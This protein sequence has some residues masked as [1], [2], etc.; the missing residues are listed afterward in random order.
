MIR[1]KLLI[2][3]LI[4][5]EFSFAQNSKDSIQFA[6]YFTGCFKSDTISLSINGTSVFNNKILNTNNSDGIADYWFQTALDSLNKNVLVKVNT[7]AENILEILVNSKLERFGVDIKDGRYLVF[8]KCHGKG[9]YNGWRFL[10]LSQLKN[11]PI[12][13]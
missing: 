4:L 10:S 9:G 11:T 12:F 3:T 2:L 1:F 7:Q 13:D 5:T 6:V 8:D